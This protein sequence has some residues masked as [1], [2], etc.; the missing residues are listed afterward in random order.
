M[1]ARWRSRVASRPS[2][3]SGSSSPTTSTLEILA[4][5]ILPAPPTIIAPSTDIISPIVA[6][7]G[8]RRRRAVLIRLG[9][10]IPVGLLYHTY[11]CRPCR[12]LTARKTIVPLLYHR[13]TLRYTSHYLDRFTSGSSSDHSSPDY[14]S[15]DYSL[16]NHSSSSYSTSD[17]TLFGHTS[18]VTT[19][20]DSSVPS[21]FVYPSPA[22][23][24][25]SSEA[26]CH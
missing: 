7:L 10:D 20:A 5:P 25:C 8:V 14:S 17:Q 18:P 6:L 13:L 23:T 9:E 4:A 3:P 22:R 1:V 11:P 15:S 24:L 16:A 26:F 21:R 2:S 19:I 12:A